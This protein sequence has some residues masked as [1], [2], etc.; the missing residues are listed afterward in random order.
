MF[1]PVPQYMSL[2]D[3]VQAAMY[4]MTNYSNLATMINEDW[5]QWGT[6]FL[7]DPYLSS[8][9]PPDPYGFDKWQDWA[10]RLVL[11]L[12]SAPDSPPN[13][14]VSPPPNNLPGDY[15]ISQLGQFLI[16]QNGPYIITQGT[17]VPGGSTYQ[18][19]NDAGTQNITDDASVNLITSQ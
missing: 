4:T 11:A 16:A 19:T 12:N 13:P 10:D 3:W 18:L 9:N 15:I 6:Q 7:E 2:D 14:N 1:I 5:K 17:V 8:L